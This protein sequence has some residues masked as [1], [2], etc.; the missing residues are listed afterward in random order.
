MLVDPVDVGIM[1]KRTRTFAEVRTKK[2]AVVLGLL[3][4]RVVEH[5]RITRT[6]KTSANRAA[7]FVDLVR[8]EDLDGEVRA[9]LTE[10]FLDSPP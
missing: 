5:P 3:L 4:S 1:L 9:W 2:N 7:H 10:A 8:V 6:I